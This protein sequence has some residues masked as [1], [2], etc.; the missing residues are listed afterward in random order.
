MDTQTHIYME[1]EAV[2]R[3]RTRTRQGP[4]EDKVRLMRLNAAT[5]R[6]M[7]N[8]RAEGDAVGRP[9]VL[10]WTQDVPFLKHNTLHPFTKQ[11]KQK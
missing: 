7:L 11:K 4:V 6:K 2:N 5:C 9:F 10:F 3:T 8:G 1:W